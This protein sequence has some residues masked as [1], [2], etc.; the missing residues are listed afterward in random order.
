M[1][2]QENQARTQGSEQEQIG[3]TQEKVTS[4]ATAQAT[5][6]ATEKETVKT[7][8]TYTQEEFA[9]MQ[10]TFERKARDWERKAKE[11]ESLAQEQASQLDSLQSQII[12]L[13]EE[14]DKKELEGLESQPEAQRLIRLRS[15]LRQ[16]EAELTKK[17][18]TMSRLQK[19]YD[20]K[21]VARIISERF[22]VEIDYQDLM[23]S[24]TY[25]E[26]RDKAEDI[27]SSKL[28]AAPK[29]EVEKP[30]PAVPH[31]DSGLST[32][33]GGKGRIWK[34]SEINNMS[35]DERFRNATEINKARKEG[36]IDYTR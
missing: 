26:M 23:E 19:E 14:I 16:K 12:K 17:E 22:G 35:S 25:L 8:K 15:Q 28:K 3:Q 34:I 10:S 27:A 33:G 11:Y 29:P 24:R 9:K 1:E 2:I 30:K 36:R 6:Q 32:I 7:E 13:T 18:R 5:V 21:E 4:Q 31:I 20:A